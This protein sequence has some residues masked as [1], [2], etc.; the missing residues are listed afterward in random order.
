MTYWRITDYRGNQREF[1]PPDEAAAFLG[2]EPADLEAMGEG[3]I[4]KRAYS[5]ETWW[6]SRV[7]YEPASE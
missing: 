4:L 7:E 3:G 6:L 5:G 2:I 1:L